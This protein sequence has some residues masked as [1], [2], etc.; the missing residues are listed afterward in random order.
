MT[1]EGFERLPAELVRYRE[2]VDGQLVS[3]PLLPGFAIAVG[4]IFEGL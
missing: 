3:S 2:L 1:I 4:E